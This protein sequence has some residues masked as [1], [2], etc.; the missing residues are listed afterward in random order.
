[1]GKR[2]IW[3]LMVVNFVLLTALMVVLTG[4]PQPASAQLG[5]RAGD[6][7]MVAAER[8]RNTFDTVYITDLVNGVILA[9]EPRGGREELISSGFRL[10]ADDLAETRRDR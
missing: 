7:V 10:F 6:Y 5:A 3:G 8:S 1:M 2:T 4:S 9:V